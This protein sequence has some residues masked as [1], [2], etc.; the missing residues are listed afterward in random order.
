MET[1]SVVVEI[2]FTQA[3]NRALIKHFHTAPR[4]TPKTTLEIIKV[5]GG[6]RC[7]ITG[8]DMDAV[9]I[10][11]HVLGVMHGAIFISRKETRQQY[12]L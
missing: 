2:D 11:M 7:S 8:P 12:G 3:E 10:G 1:M 5:D 6:V 9:A 4:L